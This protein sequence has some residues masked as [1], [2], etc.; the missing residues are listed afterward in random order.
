MYV[1]SAKHGRYVPS[2]CKMVKNAIDMFLVTEGALK[3]GVLTSIV[4]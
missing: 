4:F 2:Y 3:M 1:Q